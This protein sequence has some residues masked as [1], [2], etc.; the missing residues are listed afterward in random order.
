MKH[1]PAVDGCCPSP[2]DTETP[3]WAH[4]EKG[5][6]SAAVHLIFPASRTAASHKILI[7]GGN[8]NWILMKGQQVDS[9]EIRK[10]S[11][12]GGSGLEGQ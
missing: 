2:R 8:L 1:P 12:K 10:V 4:L 9:N 6:G 11:G 7:K 5:V 3:E